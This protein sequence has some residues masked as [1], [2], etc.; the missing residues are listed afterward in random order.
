[1]R[2]SLSETAAMEDVEEGTFIAFGE[3]GYRGKYITP[4]G[5]QDEEDLST[6]GERQYTRSEL[7]T[8][9]KILIKSPNRITSEGVVSEPWSQG[10]RTKTMRDLP[11]SS[12]VY[13]SK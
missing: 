13:A 1:M 9:I 10:P 5:K 8:K 12:W 11:V 4:S 3:V 2:K 6:E 7:H